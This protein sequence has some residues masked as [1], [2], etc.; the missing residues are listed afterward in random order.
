MVSFLIVRPGTPRS[1]RHSLPSLWLALQLHFQDEEAAARRMQLTNTTQLPW[2]YCDSS[3]Q[4][5][6]MQGT[7][8]LSQCYPFNAL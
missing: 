5:C 8:E 3:M 6:I 4:L 2:R 7:L 1:G